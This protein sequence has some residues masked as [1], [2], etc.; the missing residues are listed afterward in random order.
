M[1]ENFPHFAA[2]VLVAHVSGLSNAQTAIGATVFFWARV[3]H[4]VVYTAGVWRLRALAYF[5]GVGGEL[6]ILARLLSA[7]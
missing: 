7:A 1:L 3:A 5:A 6:L 4:A 2:L